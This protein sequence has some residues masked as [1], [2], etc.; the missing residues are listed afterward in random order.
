MQA[1]AQSGKPKALN[2]APECS[3]FA[4]FRHFCEKVVKNA[5]KRYG[6]QNGPVA[7]APRVRILSPCN[8]GATPALQQ[9]TPAGL[10]AQK[11]AS[12]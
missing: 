1:F 12:L 10:R 11:W 6:G 5:R 2:S 4:Y 7:R 3:N 9:Y 8:G